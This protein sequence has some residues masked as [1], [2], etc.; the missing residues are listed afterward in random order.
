[1]PRR[2]YPVSLDEADRLVADSLEADWNATTLTLP[3]PLTTQQLRATHDDAHPPRRAML[4]HP[5][6]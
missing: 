5:G 1:M 4:S 2:R 3:R 6:Q